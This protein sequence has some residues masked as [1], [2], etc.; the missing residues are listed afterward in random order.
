MEVLI[1]GVIS[2]IESK[3]YYVLT[4]EKHELVRCSLK[5][6]F[7]KIFRLK[8]DKLYHTDIAVVGDIVSFEMNDDGTGVIHGIA[9]RRNYLSRKAPRIKGAG[10]R[11]ERLE[12][13]IAANID[14]FIIVISVL[15]PP[16][17]NKVLDRLI[18]LGE[19]AHLNI[20]IIINKCD[21]DENNFIDEWV[22]IYNEIGYDVIK[23]SVVTGNGMK[24]IKELVKGRKNLFWG[25]SGVGKSSVLNTIFPGLS[26]ETGP[27]SSFTEKGTHRT[28][29]AVMLNPE[30]DTFII[31]TP[32]IRE[33]D[34]FGIKKEDLSHY[35]IEFSEYSANC[36]FN[37][38][39]HHHEPNCAVI[40][41]VDNNKIRIERYESYLRMLDTI[42]EDMIF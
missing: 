11:G 30:K 34:P 4:E 17:N 36:K 27:I 15:E 1:Q 42:E 23:S 9:E 25:Q 16:F 2:R 26:L 13:I 5:G 40:A 18:V 22:S 39:T 10:Y 29:T 20:S 7:K 28:V 14:H 41:A 3:D 33:I 12:Q 24:K 38:C 31:D 37:T 8:K 35:F 19:S 21:L 32:G 6:R